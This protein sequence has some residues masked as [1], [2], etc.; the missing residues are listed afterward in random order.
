NGGWT[1]KTI[2][3][4]LDAAH[5]SWKIYNSQISVESLLFKYV[6]DH[7]A[8]H[9]VGIAAYFADAAAGKL[10]QVSFVEPTFIGTVTEENDEHPPANPQLGE[11]FSAKVVN[12]LMKSPNWSSS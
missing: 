5:V 6:H 11:Q 3:E 1:Q 10:P 4:E 9:V 2:F 8:G 7:A 12:A